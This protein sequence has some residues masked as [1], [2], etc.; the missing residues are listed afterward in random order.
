MSV[1]VDVKFSFDL[2]DTN[3]INPVLV[4]EVQA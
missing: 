3:E 2:S 4:E 1:M